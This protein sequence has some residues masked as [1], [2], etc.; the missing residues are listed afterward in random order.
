MTANN[1]MAK[2]IEIII[3]HISYMRNYN[4]FIITIFIRKMFKPTPKLNY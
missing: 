1:K 4:T 3:N 2:K